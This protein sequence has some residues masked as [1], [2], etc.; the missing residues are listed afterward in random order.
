M[1]KISVFIFAFMISFV[2]DAQNPKLDKLEMLFDQGHY[3]KV[4]RKAN[5]LLDKPEYDFSMIPSYYKSLSLL[6]LSQNSHW[7]LRHPNAMEEAKELFLMV[8]RSEDGEKIFNAHMYELAWVKNDM[9][10]YASDLKR[11]GYHEKFEEYQ[12]LIDVLFE[13]VDGIDVNQEGPQVVIRDDFNVENPELRDEIVI[14][15]SKQIGVPYV[16]AGNTPEGFDCSGFTSYV[17]KQNGYELPRRSVDQYKE[18]RKV[19]KKDVM[20]GDLI[21][22]DNGSGVSH[23]GIVVSEKGEPLKM[24]HASSSK[25]VIITDVSKSEYWTKRLHGF[26]S[27]VED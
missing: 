10:A 24:I 9:V 6:Q 15:A 18:S 27:Y 4:R 25:G 17:M 16:W 1:R 19:K 22:F 20:K 8:K 2:A 14:Y 12:E 7:V 11:M 13:Q 21:F 26:G 3:K 23:V 5:R